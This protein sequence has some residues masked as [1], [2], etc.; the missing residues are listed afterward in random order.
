MKDNG[1]HGNSS[2]QRVRTTQ[3]IRDLITRFTTKVSAY[4][5]PTSFASSCPIIACIDRSIKNVL[6]VMD[7]FK[8]TTV[9]EI[10]I[11]RI[12]KLDLRVV[13]QNYSIFPLHKTHFFLK[14]SQEFT[15]VLTSGGKIVERSLSTP[16]NYWARLVNCSVL[17]GGGG[18]NSMFYV[19]TGMTLQEVCQLIYKL[20]Y[21]FS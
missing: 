18:G 5:Y 15:S 2:K 8:T 4:R 17:W 21:H 7:A 16:A 10:L 6:D 9:L 13:R 3:F 12:R 11:V 19:S 1:Q 14:K 20:P